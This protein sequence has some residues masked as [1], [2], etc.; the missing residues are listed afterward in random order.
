VPALL[1]PLSGAFTGLGTAANVVTILAGTSLGLLVGNRLPERTRATVTDV[2]GLFTVVIGALSIRP[3]LQEPLASSV[4]GG[5]AVIAILLALLGG[6]LLGSWWR[7]EERLETFGVWLRRVA[8]RGREQ[9]S[10]QQRFVNAFVTSTLLFCVGPMAVLGSLEDG[11]GQGAQL[12]LTKSVLDGFAAIAFASAL[13]PGVYASALP[14]GLYQGGLTVLAVLVGGLLAPVQVAALSVAG[15][16]ILL[17]LGVRLLG[18]KPIRVA[19]LL[20]GLVLAPVMVWLGQ[21]LG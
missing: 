16:V 1:L 15:G 11:L 7:V 21:G 13:G 19:D 5:A 18:L 8:V 6:A 4:P 12:L 9:G 14:V 17:G 2:L 10:A 3:L 20:P